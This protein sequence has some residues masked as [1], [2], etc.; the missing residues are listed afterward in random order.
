M[1]KS[2]KVI[3]IILLGI[4]FI[5]TI[6]AILFNN[7]PSLKVVENYDGGSLYKKDVG[8]FVQRYICVDG[9][10]KTVFKW[11]KYSCPV[12]DNNEKNILDELSIETPG[13]VILVGKI[14]KDEKGW[15]FTPLEVLNI[16]L[17]FYIEKPETFE[18]VTRFEMLSNTEDGFDKVIYE[19]QI[20]TITGE[21]TNPRGLGKLYIIPYKIEVGRTVDKGYA[22][23]DLKRPANN[24]AIYNPLE[25]SDK[26]KSTFESDNYVYN[27][28]MLSEETLK[29]YGNDFANFYVEFMDAYLN[30]ETHVHCPNKEYADYLSSIVYY[31]NPMFIIDTSYNSFNWYDENN[32][33]ISWTY[34][35]NKSEHDLII[36]NVKIASNN[37]LTGIKKTDSEKEKAMKL[38]NNFNNNMKYDYDALNTRNNIESYYAYI[39]NKGICVTF[40][41]AYSQLLT[42]IGIENTI[43]SGMVSNGE[44][45]VWNVINIDG[46]NY[47]SDTTYQITTTKENKYL[48]FGMSLSDRL[49]DGSNFD[50][51]SISIGKYNIKKI[52]DIPISNESL[53]I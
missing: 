31:E 22:I 49:N 46:V 36:D 44:G 5:D 37:F 15:Y 9:T 12:I 47:F 51:E 27:P 7:S 38:Y 43:S 53:N 19:K 20:V 29:T 34:T 30:Y 33:T 48:Y 17:T 21:I 16:K 25:L 28:Y 26:M 23:P 52:S 6:Q 10:K 32:K 40:A 11:E 14:Y 18:N 42:Q 3:L 1:K 45:H 2:L 8:I 24:E 35:K 41:I 50:K 39:N 13:G 4:L